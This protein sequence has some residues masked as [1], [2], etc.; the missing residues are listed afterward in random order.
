[1]FGCRP[2]A[3]EF[4]EKANNSSNS[5]LRTDPVMGFSTGLFT[6]RALAAHGKDT[7]SLHPHKTVLKQTL[8]RPHDNSP[9]ECHC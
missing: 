5:T 6:I 8:T 1:M 4:A 2:A 7:Q 3:W 9:P